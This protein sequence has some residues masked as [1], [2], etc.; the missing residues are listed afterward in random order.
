[1]NRHKTGRCIESLLFLTVGSLSLCLQWQQQKFSN[2]IWV[3]ASYYRLIVTVSSVKQQNL[4]EYITSDLTSLCRL[5]ATM[6][7]VTA[8]ESYVCHLRFGFVLLAHFHGYFGDNSTE[9]RRSLR[10]A[11]LI[12]SHGHHE[13]T[14]ERTC[15]VLELWG[16][17]VH[18]IR[19]QYEVMSLPYF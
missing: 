12:L 8:V 1:M 4:R 16:K 3:L 19:E 17:L 2:V 14:N 15:T 10:F 7:S 5:T 18:W 11:S 13:K 6:S 9:L